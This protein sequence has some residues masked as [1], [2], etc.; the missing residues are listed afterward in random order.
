MTALVLLAS[1]AAQGVADVVE[2]RSAGKLEEAERGFESLCRVHPDR[3]SLWFELGVTRAWRGDLAGSLDALERAVRLEPTELSF[4]AMKARVLGWLGQTAAAEELW[5][6]LLEA[7]PNRVDFWSGAGALA[8]QRRRPSEAKALYASALA[9]DPTFHEAIQGYARAQS[10]HRLSL[11]AAGGPTWLPGRE[12]FGGELS[13]RYAAGA[14]WTLGGVYSARVLGPESNATSASELGQRGTLWASHRS[15]KTTW[16]GSATMFRNP[17]L[18]GG[19]LG[20]SVSRSLS[21]AWSL[22]GRVQGSAREDGRLSTGGNAGLA[23]SPGPL[24]TGLGLGVIHDFDAR[25]SVVPSLRLGFELERAKAS[26]GA[27]LNA[28]RN[29]L[30]T[31]VEI[32]ATLHHAWGTLVRYDR[33]DGAFGSQSLTVGFE[34]SP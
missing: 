10:A 30:S 12:S 31:N 14:K 27:A 19:E 13:L 22:I 26:A 8:L 11:T 7:E 20:L 21:S 9:V 16:A 28:D 23:W 34:V 18:S 33:I 24:R 2:L 1:L 5:N 25:T 3:G 4:Q 15:Q 32:G 17:P 29:L 6:E